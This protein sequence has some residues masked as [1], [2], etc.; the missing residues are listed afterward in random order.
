[1]GGMKKLLILL[2]LIAVWVYVYRER[3]YVHDVIAKVSVGGVERESVSAYINASNDVLLIGP[4]PPPTMLL[5]RHGEAAPV[6]A[7]SVMCLRWV[8]CL[9]E[10][11]PEMSTGGRDAKVSMTSKVVTYMNDLGKL[12]RVDLY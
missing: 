7:G 2:S 11:R 10:E 12:V 3:L 5:I 4:P 9:T 1:M 6:I 8:A